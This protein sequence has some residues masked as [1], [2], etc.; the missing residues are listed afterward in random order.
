VTILAGNKSFFQWALSRHRI[1]RSFL[2][3]HTKTGKIFQITQNFN[4]WP[5][6][7]PNRHKI[8]QMTIKYAKIF[9]PK[10]LPIIPKLG[11]LV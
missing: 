9:L 7:I 1:T 2:V 8:Y 5:L 3:K 11:F 6:K 4:K 10:A